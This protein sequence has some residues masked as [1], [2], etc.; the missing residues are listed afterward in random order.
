MHATESLRTRILTYPAF[1]DLGM[2]RPEPHTIAVKFGRL[3]STIMAYSV[4]TVG[5]NLDRRLAFIDDVHAQ[6]SNAGKI[7][8]S[9][10]QS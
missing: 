7:Q 2:T 6:D 10:N 8:Q 9:L 5:F 1:E 3:S 4:V